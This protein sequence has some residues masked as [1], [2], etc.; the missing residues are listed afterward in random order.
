[1]VTPK[2]R[3]EGP[4]AVFVLSRLWQSVMRQS[5][6]GRQCVLP[7]TVLE[8]CTDIGDGL[9]GPTVLLHKLNQRNYFYGP[10]GNLKPPQHGGGASTPANLYGSASKSWQSFSEDFTAFNTM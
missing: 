4:A 6:V 5:S 7:R 2:S 1:M 3:M 10:K 8:T 9:H